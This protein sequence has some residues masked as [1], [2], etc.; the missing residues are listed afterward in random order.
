MKKKINL[1]NLK[2]SHF[3]SILVAVVVIF[4]TI[5]ILFYFKVSE[6][7]EKLMVERLKVQGS[8]LASFGSLSISDFLK[9]RETDLLVLSKLEAIRALKE[10]E[11][12]Q[13][14]ESTL[15]Q[16]EEGVVVGG[17]IRID[18]EGKALWVVNLMGIREGE[19]TSFSDRDYFLWAKKERE[20]EVFISR[21]L[22]SRAGV[23]KGKW[24]LVM[25]TPV[26]YQEKFNG[27]I[28][29]S[30]PL[31]N[32][33]KKYISPL[34]FSSEVKAFLTEENGR[35][36]ASNQPE[37]TGQNLKDYL[38]EKEITVSSPI[39]IGKQTF[40]L[41]VSTPYKEIV[42]LVFPFRK[43]QLL[44]FGFGLLVLVILIFV[45]I[46]GVRIAQRDGFIDGFRDGRNGICKACKKEFKS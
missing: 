41:W 38:K 30:V 10:E 14:M 31:E 33:I 8:A 37:A 18:K 5:A 20:G 12:R 7:T 35:I 1:N 29:L 2:V 6:R 34:S 3:R 23:T 19:G 28:V 27:V 40:S 4:L 11:G 39:K 36:I 46:F 43:H 17:M 45:F 44:G 24:I 16:L 22:I 25:A 9:S 21:P 42:N 15:S 32:F 13:A 26:F